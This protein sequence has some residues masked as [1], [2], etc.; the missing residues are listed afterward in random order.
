M[1]LIPK[2][3][4]SLGN[5]EHFPHGQKKSLLDMYSFKNGQLVLFP[6]FNKIQ[7]KSKEINFSQI[8]NLGHLLAGMKMFIP[9]AYEEV[10]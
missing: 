10:H 4:L 8:Y 7:V 5:A 1:P 2:I 6:L 3:S 9:S